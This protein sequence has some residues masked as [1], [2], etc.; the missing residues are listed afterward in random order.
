[1]CFKLIDI[2]TFQFIDPGVIEASSNS[3]GTYIITTLRANYGTSY[4]GKVYPYLQYSYV[5]STAPEITSIE[6][7]AVSGYKRFPKVILP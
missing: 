6:M 4:T 3:S 5:G 7:T 2:L 1:M